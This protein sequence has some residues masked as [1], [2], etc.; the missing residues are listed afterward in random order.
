MYLKSILDLWCQLFIATYGFND[1]TNTFIFM[2]LYLK[3]LIFK[4]QLKGIKELL[5]FL[6]WFFDFTVRLN[7]LRSTL[8]DLWLWLDLNLI[9]WL[10]L[11]GLRVFLL[12]LSLLL[13]NCFFFIFLRL[14][15]LIFIEGLIVIILITPSVMRIFFVARLPTAAVISET[16]ASLL[17][18]FIIALVAVA[19]V[20]LCA[21]PSIIHL[22]V[23]II[24]RRALLIVSALIVLAAAVHIITLG[25]PAALICVLSMLPVIVI[26]ASSH[27]P[28]LHSALPLLLGVLGLILFVFVSTAPSIHGI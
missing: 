21:A 28:V 19:F 15:L 2:N 23:V 4:L 9:R 11:W 22:P 17:A 18:A 20:S 24:V 3:R 5:L 27:L 8:L 6:L 7:L 26:L 14:F 12:G 1:L 25:V 13:R 10:N 16:L